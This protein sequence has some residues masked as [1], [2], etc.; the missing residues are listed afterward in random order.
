MAVSSFEQI[1][2]IVVVIYRSATLCPN[3]A[4]AHQQQITTF[5]VPTFQL[6]PSHSIWNPWWTRTPMI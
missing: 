1:S 3:T 2:A 6:E 4:T 5:V